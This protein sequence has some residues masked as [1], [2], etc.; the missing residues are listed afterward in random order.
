MK[1]TDLKVKRFKTVHEKDSN[2]NRT[3]NKVEY[4]ARRPVKVVEGGKRFAHFFID[5]ID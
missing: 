4:M 3:K 1:I 2:G 5:L